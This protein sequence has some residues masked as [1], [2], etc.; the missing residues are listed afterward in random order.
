M[1]NQRY[2]YMYVVLIKH[3]C[4]TQKCAYFTLCAYPICLTLGIF[5]RAHFFLS[6][7]FLGGGGQ[8][9]LFSA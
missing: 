1:F 9:C 8:Y 5:N 2:I 4:I 7:F 6:F 3:T